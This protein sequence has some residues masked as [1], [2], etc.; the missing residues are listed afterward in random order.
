LLPVFGD[1]KEGGLAESL[2][3]DFLFVLAHF[4]EAADAGNGDGEV[5]SPT[6]AGEEVRVGGEVLIGEVV[7]NLGDVSEVFDF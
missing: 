1:D 5:V 3:N 6:T 4:L 7:L 2:D